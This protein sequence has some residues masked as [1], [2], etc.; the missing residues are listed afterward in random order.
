MNAVLSTTMAAEADV[1]LETPSRRVL[2]VECTWMR[3]PTLAKVIDERDGLAPLWGI[4]FD[5]FMLTL[6]A[7]LY[8][9]RKDA[10]AGSPPEYTASA[11]QIWRDYLGKLAE[12]PETLPSEC[13][14][15]AVAIWLN[16]LANNIVGP[17]PESEADQLL[18]RSGLFDW[19]KGGLA[20]LRV[21]P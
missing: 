12:T 6:R 19:M 15:I 13:M 21:R 9:W 5:Y 17:N 14:E 1:V 7:E 2:L 11:M 16:N 18:L 20:Q 4:D 3:E 8:L 10:P